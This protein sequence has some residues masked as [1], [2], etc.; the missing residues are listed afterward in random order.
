MATDVDSP[1]ST[2][3]GDPAQPFD[4]PGTVRMTEEL[5][6]RYS[7]D[8]RPRVNQYLRSHRVGKGQHGEVWV[9]WDLSDNRREVAIKAVKRNNPRAEKM[10][11][12][13]RRNLPTSPHTPLTDKL[14]SL[15]QKIRKEIAIMKKC[16]HG[17]IVRLLE[18]IDDKLNERIYMVMEYLGGGE[19]KWRNEQHE[20]ILKVDQC[21]RICRDVIL[22]L[23]Y[24][25]YQGIIHRDIKPANLLWTADRQ[26]V[27]IT[28]FG[29]SHF[30]YAQRLAAAGRGQ[31]ASDDPNDP[32]L[33]DD[34]DLSKRAG[35]PPFLAPEVIAEYTSTEPSPIISASATTSTLHSNKS[36][37]QINSSCT[38]KGSPSVPHRQPITKAID[39]WA[40]G[41]TLYCLL[42]GHIPFRA[43][44]SSEYVLYNVICN[45][46]WEPDELMG[47]DR[48]ETGGRHP[49]V[50]HDAYIV[51]N[52]LDRFLQKDVR[53]R[54]TL[55]DAKRYRWF[56]NDIL[57]PDEWLRQTSPSKNDIVVV[58]ENETRTAMTTA[59]FTWGWHKRLTNRISS[60]FRNVRIPHRSSS[61]DR[62]DDE[63]EDNNIGVRSLPAVVVVG[64]HKSTSARLAGPDMR[65]KEKRRRGVRSVI[66]RN[67]STP[68]MDR[69]REKSI[70]RWARSASKGPPQD[71]N[72]NV[73]RAAVSGR[74][75][76]MLN[77][78][79][80]IHP[81]SLGSQSRPSS[82]G[83]EG[84]SAS[85][86]PHVDARSRHRFSLSSMKYW[87]PQSHKTASQAS[88]PL[89]TSSGASISQENAPEPRPSADIIARRSDEV[90]RHRGKGSLQSGH[91]LCG[92][93]TAAR[94][95]S[96]WGEPVNYIEDVTSL[97]SG[98]QEGLDDDAMFLGAG[99]VAN[100]STT[101]VSNLPWGLNQTTEATS[102]TPPALRHPQ[103][104][105]LHIGSSAH[106]SSDMSPHDSSHNRHLRSTTTSPSPLHHVAY[107][108]DLN[109]TSEDEYDEDLDSDSSFFRDTHRQRQREAFHASTSRVYE[110]ADGE[111]SDEETV[112]IEFK[113]RRASIS[114]TAASP[115]PPPPPL[116]DF[117]DDARSR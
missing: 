26:M 98:D 110:D 64:R 108:S 72:S 84:G 20:P 57:N 29:V 94:R 44:D 21:R 55:D 102:H 15:E 103:P 107:E 12:L 78:S 60:L 61:R 58:T 59:K 109:E 100:E 91:E 51:M 106:P 40:L 92:I 87:R 88:S 10:N 8:R 93:L 90:L 81:N 65:E 24:L 48:K 32:I 71:P 62:Q 33:L 68:N 37:T 115:P 13:R 7:D 73:V 49:A 14:G 95:A 39:V 5:S 99:G 97:N 17:H 101:L 74:G 1:D 105:R 54:I 117:S 45:S 104:E 6:F 4:P 42:F 47:S 11:L 89:D 85:L 79:G 31:V 46:D 23:E 27:K 25:H 18:V 9:C 96:S 28:D 43:P 82:H 53:K 38:I 114:V 76:E 113:R 75:S 16:R 66:L 34:S 30:S 3:A 77:P 56:L 111:E 52:L 69:R 2:L 67:E 36:A 116:S 112:P 63:D 83:R 41:V 19:I 22:G 80:E 86:P 70:E 50:T 35:T